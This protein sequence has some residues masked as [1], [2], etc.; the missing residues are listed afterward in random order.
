MG[1]KS[2]NKHRGKTGDGPSEY[3]ATGG[4]PREKGGRLAEKP[5]RGQEEGAPRSGAVRAGSQRDRGEFEA[6]GIRYQRDMSVN[7]VLKP[8][9]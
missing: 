6:G 5:E 4:I 3:S 7:R 8:V 2:G 1:K 9:V